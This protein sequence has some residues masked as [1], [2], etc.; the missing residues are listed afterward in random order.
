MT[1][2]TVDSL[3]C[4]GEST[5]SGG[6]IGLLMVTSMHESVGNLLITGG[7]FE[8]NIVVD[9]GNLTVKGGKFN[10]NKITKKLQN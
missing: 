4:T 1:D 9:D 3:V 8:G 10:K 6:T 7:T 5:I 2:G